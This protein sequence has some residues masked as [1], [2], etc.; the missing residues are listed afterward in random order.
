[1]YRGTNRVNDIE[2]SIVYRVV[3]DIGLVSSG[4]NGY[5]I[6]D[7]WCVGDCQILW[8]RTVQRGHIRMIRYVVAI[9]HD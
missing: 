6:S 1:M 2:D 3:S 8:N 9:A 7:L 4:T 5:P